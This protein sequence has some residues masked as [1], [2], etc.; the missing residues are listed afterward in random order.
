MQEMTMLKCPALLPC[1]AFSL[2][3]GIGLLNANSLVFAQAIQGDNT[4]S[5]NGFTDSVVNQMGDNYLITGG[6]EVGSNLFH[7]FL[8][9]SVPNFGS[10]TFDNSLAIGNIISR[11]TGANISDIQGL[12]RANGADNLFLINPNGIIFGPN[13]AL[14]IGGSFVAST[15]DSIEF[16]GGGNFSA[17]TP[18]SG[19]TLL[20]MTAPLG[21]Q[22]GPNPGEIRVRGFGNNRVTDPNNFEI[23]TLPSPPFA[24]LRPLAVNP[25]ETLALVGG[26]IVFEGGNVEASQGRIELGAFRNGQVDL[27][28]VNGQWQL[29][30]TPQAV[31]QEESYGFKLLS[32]FK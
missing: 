11:V 3:T 4:L 26:D 24:P 17:K 25:G 13:A 30:P 8:E 21:L 20:T 32:L 2:A 27:T 10:A 5:S 31:E 19:G 23:I 6:T 1:L 22:M 16:L 15:A 28:T 18:N 7:S 14:N 29:S 12:I 9:F